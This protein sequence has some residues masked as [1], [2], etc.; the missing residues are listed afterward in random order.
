MFGTDM[1]DGTVLLGLETTGEPF[2]TESERASRLFGLGGGGN[3][4]LTGA[5]L[6]LV[7]GVGDIGL[8]FID[9]EE[10]GSRVSMEVDFGV[11]FNV[12]VRV[13]GEV[14]DVE[15]YGVEREGLIAEVEG[16]IVEVEGCLVEMEG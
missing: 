4:G 7:S 12:G 2:D 15:L 9:M 10:D 3:L 13:E 1:A 11:E 6:A 8:A 5:V 16:L 14:V